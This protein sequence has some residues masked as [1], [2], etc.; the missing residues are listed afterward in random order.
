MALIKLVDKTLTDYIKLVLDSPNIYSYIDKIKV[1]GGT[2]TFKINIED[3]ST[4]PIPLPPKDE[5]I[6]I[7]ERLNTIIT[8]IDNLIY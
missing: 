5:Q 4:F 7:V 1:G 3:L 2:H 8:R 6:K